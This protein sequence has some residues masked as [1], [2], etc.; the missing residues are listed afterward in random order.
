[1]RGLGCPVEVSQMTLSPCMSTCCNCSEEE[2]A[3][4]SVSWHD[5]WFA[6]ILA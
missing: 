3:A 4:F 5:L 6:A 1:M 2:W